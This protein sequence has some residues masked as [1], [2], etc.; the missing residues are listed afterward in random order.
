MRKEQEAQN[1]VLLNLSPSKKKSTGPKDRK[2][3]S[4]VPKLPPPSARPTSAKS[5]KKKAPKV[6]V[7]ESDG[8]VSPIRASRS[9]RAIALPIRFQNRVH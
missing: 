6:V 9:G 4:K 2:A 7:I 8:E 3:P 5:P 1:P